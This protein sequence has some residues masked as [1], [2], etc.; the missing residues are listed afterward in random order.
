MIF[1]KRVDKNRQRI[2]A[3]ERPE[4]GKDPLKWTVAGKVRKQVIDPRLTKM[5]D[6]ARCGADNRVI[7]KPLNRISSVAA[8]AKEIAENGKCL[9]RRQC[10]HRTAPNLEESTRLTLCQNLT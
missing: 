6:R 3:E 4:P 2:S 5:R 9:E 1:L 8:L 7:S 10:L